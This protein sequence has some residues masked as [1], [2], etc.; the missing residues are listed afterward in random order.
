MM[1]AYADLVRDSKKK[2][3]NNTEMCTEIPKANRL[4]VNQ[5]LVDNYQNCINGT[6]K[7]VIHNDTCEV[8]DKFKYI[9]VIL[10]GDNRI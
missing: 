7:I 8:V 10:T 9:S 1:M 3:F 6:Q 4:K 2:I 5:M